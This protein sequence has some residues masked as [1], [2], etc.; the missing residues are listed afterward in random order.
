M[1]RIKLKIQQRIKRIRC[2]LISKTQKPIWPDRSKGYLTIFF[3][4]EGDYALPGKERAESSIYGVKR[5]LEICKKHNI[6]A[7][8][9]T[10]GKLFYDHPDIIKQIIGDRHD[11][12]SHSYKHSTMNEMN[13]KEIESDIQASQKIFKEHGLCLKGFRSPQSRWSFRQMRVMLENGL[14]WSAENDGANHP[15]I[16]YSKGENKLVRF[17]IKLD[18]WDY[19]S[20]KITPNE[21]Y[22]ILCNRALQIQSNKCYGAIG[23][24]PF[25]N[26]MAEARLDVFD[27]FLNQVAFMENLEV[28][29]FGNALK[30]ISQ[31]LLEKST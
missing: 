21:M 19:V 27:R 5:I 1:N 30:I 10:V 29:T 22:E 15:Y 25:V 28:V 4:Y 26:G 7:T 2:Q 31:Q 9:N 16:I 18:D 12:S 11:I 3:D 6:K 24:H 13:N 17:P 8:F 14:L 23:F 20:K